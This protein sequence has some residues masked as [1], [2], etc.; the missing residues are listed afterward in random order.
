MGDIQ[1]KIIGAVSLVNACVIER[2]IF[3]VH[4]WHEKMFTGFIKFFIALF[5]DGNIYFSAIVTEAFINPL[6]QLDNG[7]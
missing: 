2:L 5:N 6:I 7:F 4:I 3:F 1:E